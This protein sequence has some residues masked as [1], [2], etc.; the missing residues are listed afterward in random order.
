MLAAVGVETLEE[1]AERGAVDTYIDVVDA[2]LFRPSLNLLWGL[3]A[4]L[5]GIH[6][7]DIPAERK[8]Q[9]RAQVAAKMQEGSR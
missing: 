1:L 6:W 9:L 5:A 8:L 7:K 3:E 2:G 4:V